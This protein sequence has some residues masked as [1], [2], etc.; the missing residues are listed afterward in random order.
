MPQWPW[1]IFLFIVINKVQITILNPLKSSPS[2]SIPLN[3]LPFKMVWPVL[4]RN[5][6]NRLPLVNLLVTSSPKPQLKKII[7]N[8]NNFLF[9]TRNFNLKWCSC[10]SI[11]LIFRKLGRELP[12]N[13][14]KLLIKNK[15]PRFNLEKNSTIFRNTIISSINDLEEGGMISSQDSKNCSKIY[16]KCTKEIKK[17]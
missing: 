14:K 13:Q 9:R 8:I 11:S 1:P 3:P 12:E 7:S 2:C 4:Q 5:I 15:L 6:I 10:R 17:G 16:Y